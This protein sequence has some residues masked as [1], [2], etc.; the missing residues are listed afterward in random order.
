MKR[1]RLHE[2]DHSHAFLQR[3]FEELKEEEEEK[4]KEED[5]NS[6]TNLND[7]DNETN[8]EK[9]YD[10][11]YT[12]CSSDDEF[13]AS[14]SVAATRRR[15][16]QM[17]KDTILLSKQLVA[18]R[19]MVLVD[20]PHTALSAN[21][22]A[23]DR[24]LR[25][26]DSGASINICRHKHMFATLKPCAPVTI[27]TGS[28]KLVSKLKGVLSP[29]RLYNEVTGQQD[30]FNLKDTYYHPDLQG[31]DV[32]I[33]VD[34]L[35]EQ[36][37]V[38]ILGPESYIKCTDNT[39]HYKLE[40]SSGVFDFA[41]PTMSTRHKRKRTLT[42]SKSARHSGLALERAK[43]AD[44]KLKRLWHRRLGHLNE[45]YMDIT[46][47]RNLVHGITYKTSSRCVQPCDCCRRGKQPRNS[48]PRFRKSDHRYLYNELWFCDV[49]GPFSPTMQ[50]SRYAICFLEEVSGIS[51]TYY[52]K[53][54][55][56]VLQAFQA[57]CK[58]RGHPKYLQSDNASVLKYGALEEYCKDNGV[59][60]R[61][62]PR[63]TQ[64]MNGRV[65]RRFRT[66]GDLARTIRLEANLGPEWWSESYAT[67]EYILNRVYHKSRY[68]KMTP[69]EYVY[70]RKPDV[71]YFKPFG[72]TAWV[73]THTETRNGKLHPLR[74]ER[75]IFIGY[76]SEGSNSK[77]LYRVWILPLGDQV[78]RMVEDFHVTFDEYGNKDTIYT[79]VDVAKSSSSETTQATPGTI[80]HTP[81]DNP[82]PGSL[83]EPY[84]R[85]QPTSARLKSYSKR[86]GTHRKRNTVSRFVS[87]N[88]NKTQTEVENTPDGENDSKL[89]SV[90]ETY[91]E[92]IHHP[93][94]QAIATLVDPEDDEIAAKTI[95]HL[96][97]YSAPAA[98][99]DY[100]KSVSQARARKDGEQW[101]E[102]IVKEFMQ[103]SKAWRIIKR[104][105]V[106][107]GKRVYPTMWVLTQKFKQ[108]HTLD[109]Y[110]ARL[111]F[112]GDLTKDEMYDDTYAPVCKLVT[113]RLILALAAWYDLDLTQYDIGNAF[114]NAYLPEN[115]YMTI[116]EGFRD[117]WTDPETGEVLHRFDPITGEEYVCEVFKSL[118]GTKN[119][120][121]LWGEHLSE[122]L[123][124]E[125]GLKRSLVD[126]CLYTFKDKESMVALCCWVDD[127][128]MAGHGPMLKQ[129]EEKLGDKYKVKHLGDL[130]EYIGMEV[131]RDREKGTIKIHQQAFIENCCSRYNK[132]QP[133]KYIPMEPGMHY[134]DFDPEQDEY[135]TGA[136]VTTY[137]SKVGACNYAAVLTRPD[138]AY[139]M[140]VF[141]RF[142][143]NPTKRHMDGIDQVLRYLYQTKP[144]GI[145]YQKKDMDTLQLSG[146]YSYPKSEDFESP[147]VYVD[148]DWARCV[149]TRRSQ[150]SFVILAAGGVISH[151]SRRQLV[152]SKSTAEAEYIAAAEC[153]AEV[154]YLR[155]LYVDLYMP[156]E[157]PV[158]LQE[159]NQAC[160][161]LAK[162]P[163]QHK[164]TKHIA[165]KYHFIRENVKRKIVTLQYCPTNEMLSDALT[166]PLPQPAYTKLRAR[167]M[168][169]KELKELTQLR[170]EA[171]NSRKR[172]RTQ[173]V[174]FNMGSTK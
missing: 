79:D 64:A 139:S 22:F 11:C 171:Q 59:D 151:C 42:P 174:S 56:E 111:V 162:S 75:G 100:P 115:I 17:S 84:V 161:K 61:Q 85:N 145:T 38:V 80:V 114:L 31:V 119:A 118:Y 173:Q 47:R 87:Y 160:I 97:Y 72:C 50:G 53:E 141:G 43:V 92:S 86:R 91:D 66:L 70:Q 170:E 109:I 30:F 156:I 123:Q 35:I 166:K 69:Y 44:K 41:Y 93:L 125:C 74:S 140:S 132:C 121:N 148:A 58:E 20:A 108:D 4:K 134:E 13:L 168:N 146:H 142:M 24:R 10:S 133:G 48:V 128:V 29:M 82:N 26:I 157:G 25:I 165:I 57:L 164:R 67:A 95:Q 135:L 5:S 15:H 36:G 124:K 49:Q 131:E 6:N 104:S 110:K 73:H 158:I 152:T 99:M 169:I 65:E 172:K 2:T 33:S 144:Q 55:T 78:P 88:L 90:H 103:C 28:G 21:T 7:T 153:T 106:P 136:E 94:L 16:R 96:L 40:K 155:Q 14:D 98:A 167:F 54:Q 1:R 81:K 77:H 27:T 62:S 8:D 113:L 130:Q 112:R 39:C 52:A 12:S 159:D 143:Q 101:N 45:D 163:C 34:S 122:T 63:Y 126:A 3:T 138:I 68:H 120:P 116:P 127:I 37:H 147:E 105:E 32:I 71:S 23:G 149:D 117:G 137:R 129:V 51:D 83:P 150:T 60:T 9:N 102:A 154:K 107:E 19:D 89:K 18:T 46:R 76:Q